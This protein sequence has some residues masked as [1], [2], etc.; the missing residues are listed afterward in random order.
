MIDYKHEKDEADPW[1]IAL[2][3]E[4]K[5]QYSLFNTEVYLVSQEN[6]MSS[7][8]IPAVCDY[9]NIEHLSLLEFFD[10]VGWKIEF[11]FQD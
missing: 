11:S 5:S 3:L 7:Q 6:P 2:A 1:L 4:L 10:F 8:R 9:Y